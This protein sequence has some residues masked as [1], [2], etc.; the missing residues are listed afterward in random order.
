[1]SFQ[2]LAPCAITRAS[3]V[4]V[5]TH[6]SSQRGAVARFTLAKLTETHGLP[7]T[8]VKTGPERREPGA[9]YEVQPE[10]AIALG[11]SIQH[12]TEDG[13]VLQEITKNKAKGRFPPDGR[14]P[15]KT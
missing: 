12:K 2:R 3:R 10:T 9:G 5:F 8:G 4:W 13:G 7:W 6:F 15:V 11:F 1:M 14:K